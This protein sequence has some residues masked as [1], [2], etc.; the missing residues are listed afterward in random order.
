M[1]TSDRTTIRGSVDGLVAK[2][3]SNLVADPP[4]PVE[5][6]RLITVGQAEST[7]HPRPFASVALTRARP[8]GS[9]DGDK[10]FEVTIE[11][12]L[13]V[14][15]READPHGP[16]IDVLAALEDYMD[17]IVDT[18]VVEGASGFDDREWLVDYPRAT[19][20]ARV[21][22]ATAK[23]SYVARVERLFHRVPAP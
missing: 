18:G 10:L 22:S 2:L 12:R 5:P 6:L 8:L 3:R 1:P 23:Q 13:F 9:V 14:D 19:A 15:V 16:L 11:I 21:V 17:S 7:A 20:G 4:T